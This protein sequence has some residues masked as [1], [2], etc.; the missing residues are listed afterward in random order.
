[1]MK[2][3]VSRR[4]SFSSPVFLLFPTILYHNR[5]SRK[6]SLQAAIRVPSQ[7]LIIPGS[8]TSLLF[9]KMEMAPHILR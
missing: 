7:G 9:G 5:L 1:M 6:E 2:V 4:P 3:K 8:V